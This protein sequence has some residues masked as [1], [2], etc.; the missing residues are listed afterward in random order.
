MRSI[1]AFALA[2][3]ALCVPHLFA[4]A[5]PDR[6]RFETDKTLIDDTG[7]RGP[8]T[9]QKAVKLFNGKDLSNWTWHTLDEQAPIENTWSVEDGLLVCKGRPNGY[10]RTKDDYENYRLTLEWRWPEGSQPGNNGV[11]I[12]T[13]T[14][15]ELGVWPK[16]LEVQLAHQNAGDF[17]VIGTTIKVPDAERR[18]MGR[19]HLNLTDDSEKPPGEWNKM[20]IVARGA[21]VTVRV[22]GELVNEASQ[23]SQTKGAIC[24][25]SEGAAAHFR[26]IVLTPLDK[27]KP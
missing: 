25:Q 5:P 21:T 17:W 10:L 2:V 16:S 27:D 13:T 15:R 24:L 3:F 22:N 7:D 23:V 12:H 14:P 6:P 4:Q 1:P 20:E 18:V 9:G 19:R 8:Q 11:L 26:N